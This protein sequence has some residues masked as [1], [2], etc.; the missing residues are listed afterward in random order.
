MREYN[1]PRSTTTEDVL[2]LDGV[3]D[4]RKR[5]TT[6]EWMG[7]PVPRVS[8]LI[9]S[10]TTTEFL[11]KWASRLGEKGYNAERERALDIGTLA[12]DKIA[13]HYRYDRSTSDDQYSESIVKAA[14]RALGNYISWE[15]DMKKLYGI[16]ID[17][18]YSELPIATPWYGGTIDSISEIR[19]PNG[20]VE[21]VI[22]DYKT[23]KAI[24][25]NYILQTYA[26]M[27]AVN[28]LKTNN[29]R[30]DLPSIS[31]IMVV[32]VDKNYCPR[33]EHVFMDI[34]HNF[35]EFQQLERDL[36]NLINWFY[37]QSNLKYL[38][39]VSKEEAKRMLEDN[40]GE[41]IDSDIH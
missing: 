1:G 10:C 8:D 29:L 5:Y 23:S 4:N 24:S 38:L 13:N 18:L 21:Y 26:Y 35:A 39:K 22:V 12:H 2:M 25:T 17:S 30:N 28:F 7:T 40:Y 33:Y 36:G 19:F 27:W 15:M 41:N 11:I 3:D 14:N 20:T 32:R 31:G 16:E 34:Y 9:S 37:S 6:Y